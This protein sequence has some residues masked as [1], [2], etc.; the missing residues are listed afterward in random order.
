MST[1]TQ[2]QAHAAKYSD[3]R[4][5]LAD[6]VT[7]LQGEIEALQRRHM[8]EIK[9]LVRAAS[10]ARDTLRISIVSAPDLFVRP[11]TQVLSGIKC[12]YLKQRGKV[13]LADEQAVIRRIR[14][15]L[16][17]EQAELLIRVREN[18]HKPAVYDLTTADAKRLGIRIADDED[19]VVIRP[20]DTNIDK[21]V[22][23]LLAESERMEVD[24]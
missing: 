21:L 1:M 13:T 20:T 6:Q 3:L 11:R 24:E 23:A 2:I 10:G 7:A 18:V 17:T 22:A 8:S 9:R 16:P 14:T 4:S 15:L 5:V 19:V 12:G